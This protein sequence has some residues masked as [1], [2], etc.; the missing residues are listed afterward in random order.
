VISENKRIL[1]ETFSEAGDVD[2]IRALN[3]VSDAE[4]MV[5][6]KGLDWNRISQRFVSILYRLFVAVF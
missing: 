6:T 4:M 2:G 1:F 3:S 5:N